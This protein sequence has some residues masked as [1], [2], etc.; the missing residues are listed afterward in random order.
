MGHRVTLC[1]DV[2]VR[3]QL[4]AFIYDATVLDYLT[5]QDPECVLVTVGSWFAQTGY[6]VGF[7]R[8]S[9]HRARVNRLLMEYRE[10]GDLERLRRYWFVGS[11]NSPVGKENKSRSDPLAMEQFLSTFLLLILG[12]AFAGLLLLGE[13]LYLKYA[14]KRQRRLGLV[15]SC[16]NGLGEPTA[17]APN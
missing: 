17:G 6:G 11:C 3:R 8:Y 16:A 15:S 12:M 7:P 13:N 14:L 1:R 9:K 5:G 2:R 10:N 4:D